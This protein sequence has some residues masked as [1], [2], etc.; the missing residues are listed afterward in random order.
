MSK[1]SGKIKIVLAEDEEM[2][3]MAYEVGLSHHGY[4]II[5]ARDGEQALRAVRHERPSLLLLDVI[6]PRKN[7]FEVLKEI[8]EDSELKD[9]DVIMLTNLSQSNDAEKALT[10]GAEDYLIKSDLSMQQLIKHIEKAL[11]KNKAAY[12]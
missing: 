10:L 1:D 6:M 2:I 12:N 9:L 7:G 11:A 8:K 5:V 4:E 3:S